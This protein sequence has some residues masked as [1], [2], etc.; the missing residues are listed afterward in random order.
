[1]KVAGEEDLLRSLQAGE[2][3]VAGMTGIGMTAGVSEMIDVI[4]D[5]I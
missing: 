5:G 2:I 3:Q 4:Y 1:M